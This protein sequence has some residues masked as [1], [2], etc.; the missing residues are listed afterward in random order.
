M[1]RAPGGPPGVTAILPQEKG[2]QPT[3]RGLEIADRIVTS[4]AQI[5]NRV[6][7]TRGDIDGRQLARAPEA[8]PCDG[9]APVGCDPIAWRCGD[10]R[11]RDDP[12]DMACVGEIAGAPLATRAGVLHTDAGRAC[13]W[14]PT[15]EVIDGTWSR[16]DVAQGGALGVVFVGDRGDRHRVLMDIPSAIERARLWHG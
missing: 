16:P 13:G 8:G 12:A 14:Q 3:R 9:V 11:G 1:G 15:D 5:P 7:R 6:I 2:L 4:P 10:Q